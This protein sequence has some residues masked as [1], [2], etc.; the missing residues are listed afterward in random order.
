MRVITQ[1]EEELPL[2]LLEM[3]ANFI[4]VYSNKLLQLK[5]FFFTSSC[6]ISLLK[7]NRT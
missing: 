3:P 4:Q 1:W 7:K 6:D 5:T 2:R